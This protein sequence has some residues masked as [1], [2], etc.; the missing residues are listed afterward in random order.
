MAGGPDSI[1][2]RYVFNT[3]SDLNGSITG[4]ILGQKR[5]QEH[6][7]YDKGYGSS[8]LLCHCCFWWYRRSQCCQMRMGK[9]TNGIRD[10][11]QKRFLLEPLQFFLIIFAAAIQG[12]VLKDPV[13]GNFTKKICTSSYI[14][15]KIY[16]SVCLSVG[17]AYET[18]KLIHYRV[19]L[20]HTPYIGLTDV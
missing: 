15:C 9:R 20:F 6:P 5:E 19:V 2:Q 10:R 13:I 14:L 11:T 4:S 18:P 8:F 3:T 17:P 12:W 1:W 7:W 16:M